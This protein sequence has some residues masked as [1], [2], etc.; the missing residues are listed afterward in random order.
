MSVKM[1]NGVIDIGG[2]NKLLSIINYRKQDEDIMHEDIPIHHIQI[3][4]R[5][6][7]MSNDICNLIDDCKKTIDMMCKND[8]YSIIWFSSAGQYRTILKGIKKSPESDESSFKI[9]DSIKSTIGATCFS[10]SVEETERIIEEL[11]V[12]CNNFSITL[13][14]DGQAVTPWSAEEEYN[15]V[16][17]VLER[18]GGK[19]ISFNTI[20]YGNFCREDILESWSM[21]SEFGEFVHSSKIEEYHDIFEDNT[22][23]ARDVD[24]SPL[25]FS[26]IGETHEFFYITSNSVMKMRNSMKFNH[27][28][29][30]KN[31]IVIIRDVNSGPLKFVINDETFELSDNTA[32]KINSEWIEGIL[33]KI[34]YGCYVY[35]DRRD[36]L[37]ILGKSLRDKVLVDSHVT[38]FTPDEIESHKR[39]L[40]KAAYGSVIARVATRHPNTC[41][42]NYVPDDNAPCVMDL[43][44]ILI[45][46]NAEYLPDVNYKRIGKKVTDDFNMF[47]RNTDSDVSCPISDIVFNEKKLNVSIRFMINGYVSINPKQAAKVG[48]KENIDCCIFRTHTIVKDGFLNI[49]QITV[50]TDEDTFNNIE[51]NFEDCIIKY[52]AYN[53]HRNYLIDIDLTKIPII[54][55]SYGNATIEDVY[56]LVIKENCIKSSLKVIKTVKN[57]YAASTESKS[58]QVIRYTPAQLALLEEYGIKNGVYNGISNNTPKNDDCDF[59]MSRTFEFSL[60]GFSRLSPVNVDSTGHPYIENPKSGDV[61]M[62]LECENPFYNSCSIDD[63][64]II[65]KEFKSSLAVTRGEICAIKIAKTLTGGWFDSDK[66]S[67]PDKKGVSHYTGTCRFLDEV[68]NIKTTYEKSYF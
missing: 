2:E 34:A 6:G 50:Y 65:E 56:N 58:D 22:I 33:Y 43:L 18:I 49:N 14:T 37:K 32:K 52:T 55:A 62:V 29:K 35:G 19:I 57:Y 68:M 67:E 38:A 41:D 53:G 24:S 59:Y 13:F 9:L 39:K 45:N 21:Y 10:E 3:L 44:K 66:I 60:K 16:N 48:L 5:S 47:H 61:Y 20:G 17:K 23:R 30:R 15:R 31:Q 26:I 8:Y 42:D 63:L 12:M 40:K 46:G 36:S 54:N 1:Y 11:S 7:S 64:K 28:N 25:N 51:S 4:D 27:I